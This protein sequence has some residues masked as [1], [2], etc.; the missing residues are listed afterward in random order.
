[1][2]PG[3]HRSVSVRLLKV[4]FFLFSTFLF[5]LLRVHPD[6]NMSNDCLFAELKEVVNYAVSFFLRKIDELRLRL[7]AVLRNKSPVNHTRSGALTVRLLPRLL[8]LKIEDSCY[9][10]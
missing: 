2:S 9:V 10:Q 1:M 4:L 7:D 8:F 5:F 6:A 3:Q